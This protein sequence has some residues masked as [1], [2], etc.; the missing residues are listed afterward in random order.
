[1]HF[2]PEEQQNGTKGFPKNTFAVLQEDKKKGAEAPFYQSII[3]L[4]LTIYLMISLFGVTS[5]FSKTMK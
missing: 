2:Q 3:N 4:N 1:M 5:M